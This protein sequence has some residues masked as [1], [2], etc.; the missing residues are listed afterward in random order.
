MSK[1]GDRRYEVGFALG[2]VLPASVLSVALFALPVRW[3]PADVVVSL[4]V[5]VILASSATV[6]SRPAFGRAALRVGAIALLG[7]GMLVVGAAVLSLAFLA[8][9]HGDFGRGG[10]TLMTLVALLF[11]PYGLLYPSIQLLWLGPRPRSVKDAKQPG[12][13]PPSAAAKEAEAR[14]AASKPA[15]PKPAEPKPAEP[16]PAEPEPAEG[17]SSESEPKTPASDSEAP[18]G[19]SGAPA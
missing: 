12:A 10:V 8:G 3:W 15:E 4:A 16:K 17:K 2:N 7:V 9:V 11:L 5:M 19:T 18:S 6:M 13:P 14:P 1:Q